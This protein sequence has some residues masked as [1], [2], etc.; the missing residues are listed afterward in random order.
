[1]R[2]AGR[3]SS[4]DDPDRDARPTRTPRKTRRWR[5][6]RGEPRYDVRRPHAAHVLWSPT[7]RRARRDACAVHRAA[8]SGIGGRVT[9]PRRQLGLMITVAIVIANMI[10]T[11]VFTSTGFQA[12]SLHD[13]V[14]IVIAWVIGGVLALCGAAVYAELGVLMPK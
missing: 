11:G 5:Q 6:T 13:P 3:A 1:M 8:R 10:G 12:A 7:V 2:R 4:W 14:T 9:P